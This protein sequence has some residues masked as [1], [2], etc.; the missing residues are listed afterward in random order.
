MNPQS[1]TCS[2]YVLD[3]GLWELSSSCHLHLHLYRDIIYAFY[4]SFVHHVSVT[5]YVAS[6]DEGT[7]M[8]VNDVTS[9]PT[10]QLHHTHWRLQ[11]GSN[12]WHDL[13]VCWKQQQ[14]THLTSFANSSP[15]KTSN[16]ALTYVGVGHKCWF[17]LTFIG[18]QDTVTVSLRHN[19]VLIDTV[20]DIS[21]H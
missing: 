5:F 19:L 14:P 15:A 20:L 9:L 2:V 4:L 6:G 12:T 21:L 10:Q 8:M 11:G 13:M 3:I 7:T 1:T 17:T 18:H 16:A